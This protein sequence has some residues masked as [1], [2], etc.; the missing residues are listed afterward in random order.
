[1]YVTNVHGCARA[2]EGENASHPASAGATVCRTSSTTALATISRPTQGV[3]RGKASA[4]IE[5][6]YSR[7]Q[8]L[9]NLPQ[10]RGRGGRTVGQSDGRVLSDCPTARPSVLPNSPPSHPGVKQHPPPP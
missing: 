3:S 9:R 6:G 5:S 2:P 4:L 8:L 10:G 1:M 7:G